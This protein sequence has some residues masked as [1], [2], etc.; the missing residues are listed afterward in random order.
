[1]RASG[2]R[3]GKGDGQ[4]YGVERLGRGGFRRTVNRDEGGLHDGLYQACRR[5]AKGERLL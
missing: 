2:V 3:S 4:L 5:G 1:M